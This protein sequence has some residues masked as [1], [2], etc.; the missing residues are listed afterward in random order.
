MA[1]RDLRSLRPL[2]SVRI[3]IRRYWLDTNFDRRV[4]KPLRDEP[5]LPGMTFHTLRYFYVSHIRAQGLPGSISEQLTGHADE[6]THR[7]YT[8]P[9][10]GM[11]RYIRQALGE[12]FDE[13]GTA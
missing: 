5:G 11:E 3:K 7:Q 6:R 2:R 1:G 9:I 8:R 13:A 12:A 10:P 4:W